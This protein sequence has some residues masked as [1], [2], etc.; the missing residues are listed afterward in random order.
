MDELD[1][2]NGG[3]TTNEHAGQ[4][5]LDTKVQIHRLVNEVFSRYDDMHKH[6]KNIKSHFKVKN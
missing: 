4:H 6:M 3:A 5:T 2:A 1:G